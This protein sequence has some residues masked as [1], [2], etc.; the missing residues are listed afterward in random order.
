[1][2]FFNFFDWNQKYKCSRYHFQY[3]AQ[4]IARGEGLGQ[5]KFSVFTTMEL[6]SSWSPQPWIFLH[7]NLHGDRFAFAMAFI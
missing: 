6:P 1:M 4:F 7:H 3:L 2:N 5:F